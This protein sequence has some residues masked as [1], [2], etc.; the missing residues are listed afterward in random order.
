MSNPK[1]PTF[2]DERIW[3]PD[4][5]LSADSGHWNGLT[6]VGGDLSTARLLHAYRSGLFPW[7]ADP[8]TWWS[9]HPRAV[10]EFESLHVPRSLERVLRR[11]RFEVTVDRAFGAVMAGCAEPATGRRETWITAEFL[12]AYG[13]LHRHGHAHSIECWR[14]GKLAGGIY[15]V[16]MGGFFAGE[17]MF[18]RESDA[19]KVAL[20]HLTRHLQTRGFALFD[21]QMTTPITERMGAVPISRAEY[22]ARLR[23]AVEMPCRF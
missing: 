22:L 3:F 23:K 17:S 12:E 9:P 11:N 19:S 10:L 1:L 13:E 14:N 20:V 18:H 21:V 6:A 15:G 8:I 4:P 5:A 16:A 7:T 2:L